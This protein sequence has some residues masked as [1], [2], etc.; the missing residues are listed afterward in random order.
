MRLFPERACHA[1]RTHRRAE[2][3]IVLV[4]MSHDIYFVR[5]LHDVAQGV[6]HNAR[7]HPRVFFNRL[8][9]SAK[10]LRLAADIERDLIAAASERE[11]EF[12]LRLL[13]E[14]LERLI[15][16]ERQPDR[17]RDGQ[18]FRIRELTH[19]IEDV[20]FLRDRVVERRA[21]EQRDELAVRDTAHEPPE[22]LHPRVKP[23]AHSEQQQ[24]A[25]RLGLPLHN[26]IK[27]ID[28]DIK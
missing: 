12:C 15:R 4:V 23:L 28:L 3:V 26:L 6:C 21:V 18:P 13:A 22:S 20:K 19:L 1:Q 14:S 7:L 9:L 8:C 17:E 11:V 25:L 27:I 24:R 5:A 10:E 2:A 16:R